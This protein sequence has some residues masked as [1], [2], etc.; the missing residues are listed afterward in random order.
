MAW[1]RNFIQQATQFRGVGDETDDMVDVLAY[2][3]LRKNALG[4]RKPVDTVGTPPAPAPYVQP[5][6]TDDW[7][8]GGVRIF[9]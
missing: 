3:I 2:A 5:V 1:V 6:T 8:V 7:R 4:M 9:G